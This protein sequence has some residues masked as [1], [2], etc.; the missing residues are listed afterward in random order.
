MVTYDYSKY[1]NCMQNHYQSTDIIEH[2]WKNGLYYA[3]TQTTLSLEHIARFSTY[4]Y[5]VHICDTK[6]YRCAPTMAYS[7]KLMESIETC[8]KYAQI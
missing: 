6:P 1:S 4:H 8:M 3:T 5:N 7:H 2:T